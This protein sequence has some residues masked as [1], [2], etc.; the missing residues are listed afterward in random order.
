MKERKMIADPAISIPE[1]KKMILKSHGSD[2]DDEITPHGIISV[3]DNHVYFYADVTPITTLKLTNILV[4]IRNENLSEAACRSTNPDEI[5]LHINSPGGLA[6]SG[7][8]MYDNIVAINSKVP[9]WTHVE[10]QASSAATLMSI[11]GS[12]RLITPSS[13]MLIHEIR[14][15]LG[16]ALHEIAEEYNNYL[17]FESKYINIYKT[18]TKFKEKEL[19]EFLKRETVMTAEEALERGLVD[20]I[21]TDIY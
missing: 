20:E 16:G 1:L 14:G 10:G 21:G 18:H 12:H 5:H 15:F 19:K 6:T 13:F 7:F 17:K 4:K 3:F 9:I 8:M 2:D 11:A